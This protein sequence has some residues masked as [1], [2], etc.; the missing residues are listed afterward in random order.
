MYTW[1]IRN[2]YH[3]PA[4]L[5]KIA[6]Q[7]LNSQQ[8]SPEEGRALSWLSETRKDDAKLRQFLGEVLPKTDGPRL[9][10]V[11]WSRLS[12]DL[13]PYLCERMLDGNSLMGFYHRE[14]ADVTAKAFMGEGKYQVF[15]ERL[16]DYFRFKADPAGDRSWTGGHNHGLSELPYH[17][18]E[19][20]QWDEVYATLT[21]FRF[22]EE[23]AARVGV[24]ESRDEKGQAVKTYTGVLLLQEDYERALAA[25][26]GSGAGSWGDRPPLLLTA[27]ETSK[28]LMVYC[29]V[30]NQY[31]LIQRE[32]LDRVIQCPQE[33]CNTGIK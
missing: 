32:M 6:E 29:P 15:H 25:M 12:F 3:F 10:I 16:A 26:P 28:G 13:A 17:Q 24:M 5:A 14:L 2:S 20:E 22:L 27:I 18:T 9:P 8:A 19:A 11:L 7:Q 33:N 23:K 31:S 4:D 30:C 1:F 21:D